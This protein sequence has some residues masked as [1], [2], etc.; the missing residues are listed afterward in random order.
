M[1]SEADV[2]SYRHGGVV[3]LGCGC[4]GE[5]SFRYVS[6]TNFVLL[7]LL[8]KNPFRFR[9]C[10]QEFRNALFARAS[11]SFEFSLTKVI[12]KDLCNKKYVK[13]IPA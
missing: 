3:W 9:A 12:F 4:G 2:R 11:C 8:K 5:K 10:F 7:D 13:T 6:S 1:E